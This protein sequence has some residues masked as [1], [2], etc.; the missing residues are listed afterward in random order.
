MRY[1]LE[2]LNNVEFEDLAKDLLDSKLGVDFEI[3]KEGKDGGI[4]LRYTNK[5]PNEIIVQVKHYINSEFS[6]LK[7]QL[8]LEKNKL[9]K[10]VDKPK[11]YIVFTSFK[12]SPLKT[13]EIKVL[14]SPYVKRDEDIYNRRRVENLLSKYP[15]IERKYFKLWLTSTNVMK[16]IL[17]NAEYNSSEFQ[18]ERIK[19]RSKFYLQTN[20]LE[21]AFRY[22]KENKFLII[23]GEPG[24]G[25][26]TLAY[27][28]V[29]ELLAKGFKLL[30]SDRRIRDVEH[31][32]S[33]KKE[34]KQVILIDDFLGSNLSDIYNPVNTEN[35]IIS[36]I[37]QIKSSANKYL[38][39][40]S[41]TTILSEANQYF[42]HFER[43][44]IKDASN[45]E[46]KVS[47]YTKLEK[48]KILYNHL[49]HFDLSDGF[50]DIFFNK[51]NYLRIINH[52]NYYP[53]LIETL[54]QEGNFNRSGF[55]CIEDYVFTNLDNPTKIWKSAFEKQLTRQDQVFL[56]TI[57]TFGDGGVDSIVL[58]KAFENRLKFENKEG[59]IISGINLFNTC[60]EKLQNG[61]LKT[62]RSVKT[63]KLKVSFI[64]PS[65]TDFLLDY[66]RSN[67]TEKKRIWCSNIYI[68]QF[69]KRFGDTKSKFLSQQKYEEEDYIRALI[70][71][72]HKIEELEENEDCS[73]RVLKIFWTMFPLS[74]RKRQS[75]VNELLSKILSYQVNTDYQLYFILMDI[76][77]ENYEECSKLVVEKWTE[78]IDL[79][80]RNVDD[81]DDLKY[82]VSLHQDYG[83]DFNEYLLDEDRK[84]AFMVEV[85][86]VFSQMLE[87]Q[88]FDDYISYDFEGYLYRERSEER[89]TE[90][91]WGLYEDFLEEAKLSD[92]A[93]DEDALY[94]FNPAQIVDD[95][96]DSRDYSDDDISVGKQ[97]RGEESVADVDYEIDRLF[98]K[99]Y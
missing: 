32:L 19:K 80:V 10:L 17:H 79:M 30:Y 44:R 49:Y 12:L 22:L 86:K 68:E 16:T 82:I 94:S 59:N 11:R 88:I 71:R 8:A 39:F 25:K 34:D 40:T 72:E 9:D 87:D 99:R 74:V 58:E 28:V 29:Y 7:R 1:N 6:D 15:D 77:T 66:L 92:F 97:M 27:M 47:G 90:K 31:M 69:E 43:E 46:L 23:S 96:L 33:K 5:R 51:V 38:I 78:F 24:V 41:R 95:F 62:E 36:F 61:F 75:E 2:V 37:D 83:R 20:H 45:Y 4:D 52:P 85:H 13:K 55:S 73:F 64:N 35:S 56:E 53:R 42:E 84:D 60:L 67:H 26:T 54:A 81:S 91:A 63:S 93:Y 18:E 21:S 76:L 65:I 14:L 57:F 50:K 70:N 98:A 48:A 89:I 3:F